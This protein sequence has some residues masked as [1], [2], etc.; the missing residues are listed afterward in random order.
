MSVVVHSMAL[1]SIS[2]YM[3]RLSHQ[4]KSHFVGGF[5]GVKS[6]NTFVAK[7]AF[8]LVFDPFNKQIDQKFLDKQVKLLGVIYPE[9]SLVAWYCM[10]YEILEPWMVSINSLVS[11]Y[12][13]QSVAFLLISGFEYPLTNPPFKAFERVNDSWQALDST[14]TAE[15]TERIALQ[16]VLSA[17]LQDESA[18]AFQV[19]L[20]KKA[21]TFLRDRIAAISE[22]LGRNDKDRDPALVRE[23]AEV[24]TR[25]SHYP[26][27]SNVHSETELLNIIDL[28]AI[29]IMAECE[30]YTQKSL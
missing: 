21:L 20:Q 7:R 11:N 18:L 22:Y 9:E 6:E 29:I 23:A 10:S 24:I 8:E 1:L 16:G 30:K 3:A 26:F 14:I 2:D 28:M 15:D 25:L 5:Y 27:G 13:Q 17:R 12:A 4:N 19:N